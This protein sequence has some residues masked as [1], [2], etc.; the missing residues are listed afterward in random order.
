MHVHSCL[1]VSG[2]ASVVAVFTFDGQH[3]VVIDCEDIYLMFY[4]FSAHQ[5]PDLHAVT[6]MFQYFAYVFLKRIAGGPEP[7]ECLFEG[8]S[9]P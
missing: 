4:A 6:V 9:Q 3:L 2:A 7:E 5:A 8:I 1:Y